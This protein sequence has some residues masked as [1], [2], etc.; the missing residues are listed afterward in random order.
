MTKKTDLHP[1]VI[2]AQSRNLTQKQTAALVECGLSSFKQYVGAHTGMSPQRAFSWEWLTWGEIN[3]IQ[4]L[5]WHD[6]FPSLPKG[7]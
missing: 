5:K 2:F 7:K 4:C 3:A 1:A 6:R